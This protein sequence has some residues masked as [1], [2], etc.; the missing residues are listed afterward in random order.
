M[1]LPLLC[2]KDAPPTGW[3]AR[4]G[5]LPDDHT[6]DNY[7]YGEQLTS[8]VVVEHLCNK[9]LPNNWARSEYIRG[10]EKQVEFLRGIDEDFNYPDIDR[11]THFLESSEEKDPGEEHG[12]WWFF[13]WDEIGNGAMGMYVTHTRFRLAAAEEDAMA[14]TNPLDRRYLLDVQCQLTY[15]RSFWSKTF[16]NSAAYNEGEPRRRLTSPWSERNRV[17]ISIGE[18]AQHF[19]P[20]FIHYLDPREYHSTARAHASYDVLRGVNRLPSNATEVVAMYGEERILLYAI[21]HVIFDEIVP[22]L[23]QNM[24]MAPPDGPSYIEL[25]HNNALDGSNSANKRARS[26]SES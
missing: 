9:W 18:L 23:V 5:A 22:E 6:W 15:Y 7:V 20:G 2:L 3:F 4:E 13:H 12:P 24:D 25:K 26:S 21:L 19:V 8:D 14:V 10:I 17:E 11:A 1:A 16:P